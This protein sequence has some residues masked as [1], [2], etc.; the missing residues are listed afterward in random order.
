MVL[1][2]DRHESQS[3]A[4]AGTEAGE[5]GVVAFRGKM[6]FRAAAANLLGHADAVVLDLEYSAIAVAARVAAKPGP[7]RPRRRSVPGG[8]AASPLPLGYSAQLAQVIAHLKSGVAGVEQ[9]VFQ[10]L[11]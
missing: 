8:A 2:Y 10:R 9:E 7:S 11:L 3:Q 6:R 1:D 5:E 4:H